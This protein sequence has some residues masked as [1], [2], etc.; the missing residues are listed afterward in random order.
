MP[1]TFSLLITAV[2]ACPADPAAAGPGAGARGPGYWNFGIHRPNA[3]GD[4]SGAKGICG[5]LSRAGN[6]IE[7][8][9]KTDGGM[10]ERGYCPV[11]RAGVILSGF[12]GGKRRVREGGR[13]VWVTH[14]HRRE[15][16]NLLL[17]RP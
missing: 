8:D 6:G 11:A 10:R 1:T 12:R 7:T 4:G 15:R 9:W 14:F 13:P 3:R 17:T 16:C 5:V 2:L